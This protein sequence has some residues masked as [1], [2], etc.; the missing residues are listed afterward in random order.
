MAG[1]DFNINNMQQ[2]VYINYY[3]GTRLPDIDKAQFI[4]ENIPGARVIHEP[5]FWEENI[6]VVVENDTF[7]AARYVDNEQFLERARRDD[8]RQK[9]WLYVPE[10]KTLCSPQ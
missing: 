2:H 1:A 10:A 4:L 5:V 8:G 7:D 6:V 9:T 3:N